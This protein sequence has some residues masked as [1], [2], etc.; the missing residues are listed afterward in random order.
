[1]DHEHKLELW[2]LESQRLK[3]ETE[4]L[5]HAEAGLKLKYEQKR[6]QSKSTTRS[7]E[8]EVAARG[9]KGNGQVLETVVG[10]PKEVIVIDLSES[11]S[12]D[13]SGVSA[14]STFA[15]ENM[16]M[17][18]QSQGPGHLPAKTY[19]K[20]AKAFYRTDVLC[21]RERSPGLSNISPATAS[22]KMSRQPDG[23]EQADSE[24]I[25]AALP[26]FDLSPSTLFS[27][28]SAGCP[29]ASSRS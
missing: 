19:R 6:R 1:M 10:A 27:R 8:P 15:A 18:A 7:C 12:E 4:K 17:I 16:L 22:Q 13:E 3:L 21:E 26:H 5:K 20:I 28:Q 24:I 14:L 2:R 11:L 9:T 25:D 23:S 29:T